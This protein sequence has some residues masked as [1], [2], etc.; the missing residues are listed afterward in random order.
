[1]FT[2]TSRQSFAAAFK[3]GFAGTF[4]RITGM[5]RFANYPRLRRLSWLILP[6]VAAI[7][8]VAISAGSPPVIPAVNLSADPL[9]AA[10][11]GDKPVLALALSVEFP[12]VGAQYV[13]V[14]AATTDGSY[15]NTKEYLGY[16]DAESCYT[17]NNAPTETAVAPL[18]TADYKRFD[19]VG[20]ASSRMCNTAF[21]N[22]FS[23]N[24]LNWASSSAIDMLRLS[25][26]GGDRYIDTPQVVDSSGTIIT[27]AVTILQRAVIPNGD[28]IC[29]WNSSNFPAKQLLKTGGTSGAA[30]FGA[31][32]TSM[33]TAAGTSDIWIAN[34]LNKIFFGTSQAGGCGDTSSYTLNPDAGTAVK[35]GPTTSVVSTNLPSDAVLLGGE[36]SNYTFSGVKEIWFGVKVKGVDYWSVLPAANGIDCFWA[37]GGGGAY[38][39]IADPKSSASKSCYARPYSGTWTPTDGFF[40]SRVQVCNTDSAGLLKDT[41]DYDLCKK[42]PNGNYKP[43]GA[44]QKYSDQLR[45]AAFGYLMDQTAS[46]S[47]GRYGGV[48]RAPVKYVGGKTFDINGVEN[49]P[50]SGNPN[51]EWN[52]TTGV[53][54]VN[55]ESDATYGKSG[56][57]T[58]VNQFGRTGPV[59][60]R[61]KKYDPVGELHY[62]TLR[63]LQGLQPSADAISGITSDM[64]DGFPVT[65]TWA[66][67]YGGGRSAT[68][69]YSCLKSNI[70][71]V[72]DINTHDGNRLPA[73]S[74]ANNIPDINYWRS[75]VQSFELD[76]ATTYLDGQGTSRTTGNP[77]GAN[78]SVPAGT[79]TSQIMGSAY[80][81]RTHDIRST[82]WT[83][84]AKQRPG[85]RVK[86][87]T[88]DVNEYAVQNNPA[89]RRTA[90]QFFMASK[91]GGFETDAANARSSTKP[92]A[93]NTQGNPFRRDDG[94][95]D[96]YVW[97]DNDPRTS[98]TGE[99]NTYF[100]Q[101][102]ARGVLSAFDD[103]FKRS[104]DAAR[105]IAGGAIQSKSLTTAGDTIYQGTFDVS[106]WSGDLLAIPVSVSTTS[107]VSI[108]TTTTWTAASK[109]NARIFAVKPRNI[110]V[111][112]AGATKKP[113]GCTFPL[114]NIGRGWHRW[115]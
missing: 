71:V 100:L 82:G 114:V 2:P 27:P 22:A 19:R 34:T 96:K 91:Y 3:A 33:A 99:A 62:E 80:W 17:Y 40:Y 29:M 12:T 56:V 25:L 37:G 95:V 115:C 28:P 76:L 98:R 48:L 68:K 103:I 63:Y 86:T 74:V 39:G 30:Y 1:M 85:L 105:S 35:K 106:D 41:R 107:S 18:T 75:I 7:S 10:A 44:I 94:T 73:A 113:C 5:A 64:Y 11:G 110:V 54:I 57:I 111:G 58:Y 21:P 87:F 84:T 67:P 20:A 42:Y 51:R 36:N 60:G 53:F 24:V 45:L 81:A 52:E 70:V 66:D 55:P 97:E 101:S 47:S 93:Y 50:T 92:L 109:L 65:T 108:G 14:P 79:T 6:A 46:Y 43:A 38:G 69:D 26:T 90:N 13:D 83:D 49:T 78:G 112:N 88:F 89:I 104:G 4:G 32:P 16:Y 23:G 15:S 9:Y 61:Y 77:N 8:I 59:P 102:D 72:G 31:V